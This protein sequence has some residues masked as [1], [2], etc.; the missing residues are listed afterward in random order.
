MHGR[1]FLVLVSC[2]LSSARSAELAS[3]EL[4]LRG[5]SIEVPVTG[6]T[7]ELDVLDVHHATA[8]GSL[9]TVTPTWRN[10]FRLPRVAWTFGALTPGS[11]QI[12]TAGSES[13]PLQEGRDYVVNPYW[14]TIGR[15][16]SS[17]ISAET[18]VKIDFSYT[19]S[20]IDLLQR[21]PDGRLSVVKGT[22]D[23][24]APRVPEPTSDSEP[25]YG[26]YLPHNTTALHA[27]NL[28]AITHR[29]PL[30]PPVTRAAELQTFMEGVRKGGSATIVFLGD[31]ITAQTD[32]RGGSFVD[33]FTTYLHDELPSHRVRLE[34]RDA[35]F[36]LGDH[37]VVVV[38]AGVG[39]NNSRQGLARFQSDVARHRPQVVVIM[40][41]ANDENL[42]PDGTTAVSLDAYREN[43]S[44]M[45]EVTRGVGG[46]PVIM[47]PAMKNLNWVATAGLMDRF[48][49]EASRAA[50]ATGVCFIDVHD[51]WQRIPATG[52][53]YMVYLN[54]SINH[55]NHLGHELFARG[56]RRAFD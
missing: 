50:A 26:V 27:A 16:P 25:R 55:P 36:S 2:A 33:R 48:S 31:S 54:T 8:K 45:I 38:Q 4:I 12:T 52:S 22:A 18:E 37:E 44:R 32:V 23:M 15:L 34:Q 17:S 46:I 41:G 51:A 14:G 47:S 13:V 35:R 5:M 6:Q 29:D 1:L 11:V 39:G 3:D 53:D 20:R 10:G 43:L 30:I 42:R 28:R 9:P 24:N 19:E 21:S 40:F 7:L 49:E 56:L